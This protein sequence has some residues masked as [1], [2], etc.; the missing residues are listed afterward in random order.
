[1][2]TKKKPMAKSKKTKSRGFIYGLIF[3]I[4]IAAGAIYYY[5]NYYRK[6]DMERKTEKLEKQAKKEL[7]K[8]EEGVK[9]LFNK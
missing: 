4:I 2:A 3:G 1:M 8:A 6:S 9:K 7:E 5:N